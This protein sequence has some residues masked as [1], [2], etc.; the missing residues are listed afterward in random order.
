[1]LIIR[2]EIENGFGVQILSCSFEGEFGKIVCWRPPRRFGKF[3]NPPRPRKPYLSLDFASAVNSFARWFGI[4]FRILAWKTGHQAVLT[5]V[6]CT[7]IGAV[8]APDYLPEFFYRPT[9]WKES[10]N[11]CVILIRQHFPVHKMCRDERNDPITAP[12]ILSS[13][14]GAYRNR[15]ITNLDWF[16]TC[17]ME[18]RM[19]HWVSRRSQCKLSDNVILWHV[20]TG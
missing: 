10:C 15:I 7:R 3:L 1:M 9:I 8:E 11:N 14:A 20:W 12:S 19:F 13:N 18:V 17:I 4:N 2:P 6:Q 16:N 5:V